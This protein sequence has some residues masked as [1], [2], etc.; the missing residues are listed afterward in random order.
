LV[1]ESLRDSIVNRKS[2][3]RYKKRQIPLDRIELALEAATSAPSAHN[4]Q[5]WRFVV[6]TS[7]E[8]KHSLAV[9]MAEGFKE[10][11][12]KGGCPTE[13]C[14]NIVRNSITRFSEAPALI[15]PCLAMKDMNLYNDERQEYEYVMGVQSVSAAIS[16]FL[17]YAHFDGLGACWYCAPLFCKSIVRKELNIP[18]DVEPQALI[19]L[20]YPDKE[21]SKPPRKSL[22]EVIH[23]EKWRNRKGENDD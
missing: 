19:T 11:L 14:E 20:G 2:I 10:D 6:I 17:L 15:I 1:G 4:A 18:D 5:P 8:A 21:F 16:N 3:R 22:K 23:V 7:K 9:A 13:Q 12:K